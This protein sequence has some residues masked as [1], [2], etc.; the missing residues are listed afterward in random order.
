MGEASP[1][2]QSQESDLYGM[3]FPLSA[4]R[5]S[6]RAAPGWFGVLG[7]TRTRWTYLEA[8][9]LSQYSRKHP[10]PLPSQEVDWKS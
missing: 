6:A 3:A 7:I 5:L 9:A 8:K 10:S 2:H 1:E 4:D